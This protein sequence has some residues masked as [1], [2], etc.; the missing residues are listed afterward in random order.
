MSKPVLLQ[1][2]Q[3][4]TD[5]RHF[6]ALLARIDSVTG[7]FEPVSHKTNITELHFDSIGDTRNSYLQLFKQV[8]AIQL[9]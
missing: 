8:L 9:L 5:S 1:N 6:L 4:E 7:V 3:S 2:F